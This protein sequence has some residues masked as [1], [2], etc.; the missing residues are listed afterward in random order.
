MKKGFYCLI[1]IGVL[2]PHILYGNQDGSNVKTIWSPFKGIK[3]GSGELDISG[4]LRLRYEYVGNY[5]R[6]EYGLEKTTVFSW[7]GLDYSLM[8]TGKTACDSFCSSR[9]PGYLIINLKIVI[10]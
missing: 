7:S 2:I 10:L 6:K 3:V 9:M 1:I 8:C 5:N 4:S